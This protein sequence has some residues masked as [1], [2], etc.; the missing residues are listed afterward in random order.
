MTAVAVF[1]T[2]YVVFVV[3]VWRLFGITGRVSGFLLCVALLVSPLWVRLI[4]WPGTLSASAI[5]AAAAVWTLPATSRHRSRL[6][7][8]ALVVGVLSVLT[9]PPVLGLLL[10]AAAVHLRHRPWKDVL[11]VVA[12]LLAGFALGVVVA[13]LLNR[14]AFGHFGV[15]IA[16][17]R[18]PRRPGDLHDLWVNAV[19]YR[20]QAVHLTTTLGWASVL[21]LGS[22]VLALVDARVRPAFLK[23]ATAV[24]VVAGLECAQTLLTGVR[25]NVRGS[26]WAWLAVVVVAG[27]LLAGSPWSRRAGQAVLLA[28]SVVGV[29]AW[30]ADLATHQATRS[31][32]DEIVESALETSAGRDVV[33]YQDPAQRRTARGQITAGTLRMMFY[34][35]AGVVVRWCRP[36]Q[37][38]Q[39]SGL[40]AAG[41]VH[42]LGSVTGVVVPPP[43]AT[44]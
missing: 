12:T 37:C 28:L 14:I 11:L 35:D 40:A 20:R 7:G 5:V 32:Y 15:Q 21:G 41:S 13:F 9:Y 30:R 16:D 33:F 39:L 27:L 3:G 18:R 19:A 36:A 31:T 26:L 38:R 17:W 6:V 24:A 43:P 10:I 29:L 4:Y 34:E 2:A 1:V 22:A 25:T 23:V 44:L 42:D 8:W